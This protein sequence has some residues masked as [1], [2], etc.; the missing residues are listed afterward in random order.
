MRLIEVPGATGYLD[1][2]YAAKGRAG[3]EAL[4]DPQTDL[5]IVHV[6]APDEAGHEGDARAKVQAIERTDELIVGPLL[7]AARRREEWRM[8]VAPDH[9]TPCTTRAHSSAPPPFCFAGTG[10]A[11]VEQTT[12]SEANAKESELFIKRGHELMDLFIS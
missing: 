4:D 11:A 2:D 6:E 3:V 7:A 10:V 12:F 1:T 8:L 9:P 5:V